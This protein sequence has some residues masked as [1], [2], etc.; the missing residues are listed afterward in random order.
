MLGAVLVVAARAT[1][2]DAAPSLRLPDCGAPVAGAGERVCLA[3]E[4][5]ANGAR[6]AT[7]DAFLQY[8]TRLLRLPAGSADVLEGPALTSQQ[9]LNPEV[10]ENLNA[11]SGEIRVVVLHELAFPIPVLSDGVL[12]EICFTVPAGAAPGCAAVTFDP[13]RSNAGDDE[14]NNLPLGVLDGGGLQL[15]SCVADAECDD[16]DPCTADSCAFRRQCAHETVCTTT[17]TSTMLPSTTTSTLPPVGCQTATTVASVRCRLDETIGSL[18][19]LEDLG[20]LGGWLSKRLQRAADRLAKA[21]LVAVEG[22]PRKERRLLRKGLRLLS[23]VRR[24]V[25]SR[26]GQRAIV[27]ETRERLLA[28]LE[29]MREDLKAAVNALKSGGT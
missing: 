18:G 3:L 20:T 12:V 17:T 8:D 4:F 27:P 22:P 29:P 11:A 14:G 23:A 2:A 9:I 21:E 26:R 16:G 10:K 19:D 13:S 6:V 24:R 1:G 7:V 28:A 25:R 5:A 15:G